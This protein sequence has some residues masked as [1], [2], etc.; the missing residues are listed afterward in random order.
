MFIDKQYIN[1][2]KNIINN[3]YIQNNTHML[4][5][6]T[7]EF[8]TNPFPLMQH[9]KMY[10][11]GIWEEAL[12]FLKGQTDVRILQSKNVHIW[13][14]NADP[15]YKKKHNKNLEDYDLGPIYGY[16]WRNF[17]GENKDQLMFIVN[18]LKNKTFNRR[19]FMSAWNPLQLDEMVLP[20]CH[21]SYHFIPYVKNENYTVDL[22]MY[23]RSADVILGLP[24]NIASCAFI[25]KIICYY[26]NCIP[27]NIKICIGNAH[28]YNEH[29]NCE[30]ISKI[31]TWNEK[32]DF[33]TVDIFGNK[34][35]E[36]DAFLETINY[37][38][39]NYNITNK[40]TFPLIV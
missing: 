13:D 37:K 16:Q 38:L 14:A 12:F 15:E 39:N 11:K 2:V 24:F 30:N 6:Q 29:L 26:C 5:M 22:M 9:K 32:I 35:L 27:G 33:V 17:N 21:V 18:E 3:G 31:I 36:F 25:L 7:V 19:L 23:Q 40:L 4:P 20:P 1:L 34:N 28:I 8:S 10:T